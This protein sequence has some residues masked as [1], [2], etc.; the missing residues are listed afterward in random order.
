ML[1]VLV[2]N[3]RAAAN[4]RPDFEMKFMEGGGG[5]HPNGDQDGSKRGLRKFGDSLRLGTNTPESGSNFDGDS[6]TTD[7]NNFRSSPTWFKS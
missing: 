5:K 2:W 4:E 7:D 6:V 1:Y 3:S